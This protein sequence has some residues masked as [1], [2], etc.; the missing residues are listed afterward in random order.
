MENI[1]VYSTPFKITDKEWGHK[2]VGFY[3]GTRFKLKEVKTTEFIYSETET[4]IICM[5][6]KGNEH[7]LPEGLNRMRYNP[8][9]SIH[10]FLYKEKEITF[11]IVMQLIEKGYNI[12]N[13]KMETP[14]SWNNNEAEF[15]C[16]YI[17]KSNGNIIIEV[18][19]DKSIIW[20]GDID[21]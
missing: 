2:W 4:E 8:A 7:M 5:F 6:C 3:K 16:R 12:H 1:L 21:D 19:K 9:L 18:K 15:L 14:L 17:D 10:Y 13:I 11:E 20:K